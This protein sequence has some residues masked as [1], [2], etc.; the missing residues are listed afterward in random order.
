MSKIKLIIFDWD[1][2]FTL[3]SKDGYF[4]CYRETLEELGV[5]LTPEEM[6]KRILSKWGQPHREELKALLRENPE[7]LEPACDIYEKKLFGKTYLD[8]L[9]LVP[10]AN[11]LL[12]RLSKTYILAVATGLNSI[13]MKE[14][15]IPRFGVPVVF[16]SII[17]TYDI[18]DAA[19]H[20]PSPYIAKEL[21]KLY[22]L[23]PDEALVVGDSENDVLMA[24]R[25][26]IVP[27]VVLTGHLNRAEAVQ[28]K[29]EHIID[30]VTEIEKVLAMLK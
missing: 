1:D 8:R 12:N 21:L 9:S 6:K 5:I 2:V 17:S 4:K 24:Q 27:V 14:R 16:S 11:E 10:G 19:N 26:D 23:N 18:E 28:L 15:V 3:G 7:L 30:D 25:A 20:K 29:V 22:N 13:L